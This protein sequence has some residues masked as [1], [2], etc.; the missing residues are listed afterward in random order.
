MPRE[1]DEQHPD[2]V[3]WQKPVSPAVMLVGGE[4][5]QKGDGV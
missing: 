4:T 2:S 1:N 5:E 3:H